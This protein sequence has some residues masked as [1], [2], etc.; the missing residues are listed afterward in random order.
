MPPNPLT[1]EELQSLTA[2]LE[3]TVNL[4]WPPATVQAPDLTLPSLNL[5]IL[6]VSAVVMMV[7]DRAAKRR[8]LWLIR[9]CFALAVVA[10]IAILSIRAQVLAD[11]G[12]KWS[13]HAYG[14]VIWTMVGMHTFHMLAA[15]GEVALLLIYSLVRPITKK[16]ILDIRATVVYWYFVVAVWVPHYV[17]IY[18]VPHFVRKG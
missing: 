1:G 5:G 7:A 6:L 2:Y 14:S 18:V 13:S 17:I 11:L 16:Q 8:Q 15:T 10:G 3:S 4:D 9:L 12:Y